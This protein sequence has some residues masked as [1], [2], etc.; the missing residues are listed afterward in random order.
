MSVDPEQLGI[1]CAQTDGVWVVGVT[2]EIDLSNAEA[3]EAAVADAVTQAVVLDLSAVTV[4]DSSG[5]R[6]ID[7]ARR[8]LVAAERSLIVVSPPGTPSA[9]TLRI[10]GFDPGLVVE[11]VDAALATGASS[12]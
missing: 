10:A 7:G 1:T 9:W 12:A 5:I 8:R 2:G 11:S 4:L 3:M 6:A